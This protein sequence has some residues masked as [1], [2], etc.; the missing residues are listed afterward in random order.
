MEEE[1]IN[2]WWCPNEKKAEESEVCHF[3]E[4]ASTG[5]ANNE[6][7][8]NGD[9]EKFEEIMTIGVEGIGE[10]KPFKV[11]EEFFDEETDEYDPG[12]GRHPGAKGN[13]EDFNFLDSREENVFH[14][15][16]L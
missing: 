3:F 2:D 10:Q 4:R 8:E 7:E 13:R 16:Q 1:I 11:D 9:E 6:Q 14:W 15:G 5:E 12:K